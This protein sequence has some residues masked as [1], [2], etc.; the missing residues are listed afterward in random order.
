MFIAASYQGHGAPVGALC[1]LVQ[2]YKHFAPPEQERIFALTA[3][4][5]V[6]CA[7]GPT[8]CGFNAIANTSSS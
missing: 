8:C 6:A 7:T 3:K 5:V 4:P 1:L 2:S